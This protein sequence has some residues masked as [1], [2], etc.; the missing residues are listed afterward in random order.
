MSNKKVAK[1]SVYIFI[2]EIVSFLLKFILIFL[3]AR[4]LG[5]VKYGQYSAVFAFCLLLEVFLQSGFPGSLIKMI[6]SEREKEYSLALFGFKCQLVLSMI[7]F[8]TIFLGANFWSKHIFNDISLSFYLRIAS[9]YFVPTS[10]FFIGHSILIGQRKFDYDALVTFFWFSFRFLAI[11]I[12]LLLSK[13]VT[14]VFIA[15][16]IASLFG[17]IPMKKI[18]SDIQKKLNIIDKKSILILALALIISAIGLKALFQIDKIFVK[19]ILKKDNIVGIYALASN[20]SLI[21]QFFVRSLVLTLYPSVATSF[22]MADLKL[23]RK[24]LIEGTRYMMLVLIPISFGLVLIGK[25]AILLFF[26]INYIQSISPFIVL[27][28]G[29]AF[30]S[31][32]LLYR[33]LLVSVNK[34][35]INVWISIFVL[36]IAVILNPLL[37]KKYGF[38]GAAFATLIASVIGAMCTGIYLFKLMQIKYPLLSLFRILFFSVL[39]FCFGCMAAKFSYTVRYII[40][41]IL[42]ANFMILLYISKEFTIEDY[43]VVKNIFYSKSGV[44]K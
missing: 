25:D 7:I 23:T 22:A 30:F 41:L 9:L 11:L 3:L 36:I 33:Q 38:I 18:I 34:E 14:S 28:F 27:I 12:F 24:Y 6:A 42:A 16:F 13:S 8:F 37:I 29:S 44:K 35:W 1:G 4:V 17:L 2:S 39:C 19:N 40:Y 43:Q 5:P 31:F 32:F 20:F 15:I 10:I 21:I 26:G